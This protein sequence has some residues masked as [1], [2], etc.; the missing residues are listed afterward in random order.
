MQWNDCRDLIVGKDT[1]PKD[2]AEF[3]SAW[4]FVPAAVCISLIERDDRAVTAAKEFQRVGLDDK[5]V[6]YR[7]KKD[8]STH[9]KRATTR[10]CWESHRAVAK[11]ALDS[12][13]DRVLVFEDDVEFGRD[14]TPATVRKV[15]NCFNQM[16]AGWGAFFL[17]H[18]SVMSYIIPHAP[19]GLRKANSL[20]LHAYIMSERMMRWLVDH[21]YDKMK[22][23]LA[24]RLGIEAGIDFHF[25]YQPQ[26][27]AYY[28]ML[29]F[30]SGSPSDTER[31][32]L[33]T[34]FI[35]KKW[36]KNSEQLSPIFGVAFQSALFA[37]VGIITALLVFAFVKILSVAK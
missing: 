6:F 24:S 28:P 29:C 21:S 1:Q 11:W 13:L 18:F 27:Y 5:V 9:V 20:C 4:G 8:R 12:G 36:L 14:V 35:S 19:D 23:G 37:M 10:G 25:M 15:A 34:T 33:I 32:N 31:K 7:P 16:P 30:Q 22:T 26:C 17:G 2:H 3:K